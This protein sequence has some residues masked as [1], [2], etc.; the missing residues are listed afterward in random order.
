MA[1]VIVRSASAFGLVVSRKIDK[2]DGEKNKRYGKD[3][4]GAR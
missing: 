4:K 2:S 1:G 3:N